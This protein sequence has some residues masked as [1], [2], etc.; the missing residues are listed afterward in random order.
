MAEEGDRARA[1]SSVDDGAPSTG[2][3]AFVKRL[4]ALAHA[5]SLVAVPFYGALTDVELRGWLD[6][7][8]V[9]RLGR[10]PAPPS[11]RHADVLVIVGA[12]THKLAPVLQRA[13]ADLAHPALVVHVTTDAAEPRSYAL[14]EDVSAVVPIDLVVRALP[15]TDAH[16][17]TCARALDALVHRRRGTR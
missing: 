10:A 7:A 14:V 16:L 15:P 3:V 2:L 11:A 1:A 6:P 9:H 4:F 12:I 8:S 5:G 17:A 13:F